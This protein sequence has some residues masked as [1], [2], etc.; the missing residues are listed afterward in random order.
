MGCRG[1]SAEKGKMI[2]T[3]MIGKACAFA[4]TGQAITGRVAIRSKE[5]RRIVASNSSGL[6]C[7]TQ[8]ASVNTGIGVESW[9]GSGA[10]VDARAGLALYST[11]V[12]PGELVHGIADQRVHD[13]QDHEGLGAGRP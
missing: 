2:V 12:F 5:R 4:P 6:C 7:A 11:T 9:Q 1:P 8:R 3:G 10:T 13:S